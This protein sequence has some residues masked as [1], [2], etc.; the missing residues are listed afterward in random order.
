MTPHLDSPATALR[1]I[2]SRPMLEIK[3]RKHDA[4]SYRTEVIAFPA[5]EQNLQEAMDKIGVGIT[6]EKL[7][8]VDAVRS[9]HGCL[10]ALVGTLVNVDEVQYLARPCL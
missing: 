6:T 9:A 2:D 10:Q 4:S 7:C 3:L 5:I 8:L 1:E